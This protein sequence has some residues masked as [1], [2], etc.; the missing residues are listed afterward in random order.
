LNVSL[1]LLRQNERS[2]CCQVRALTSLPIVQPKTDLRAS[3]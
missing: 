1:F 3:S 2:W